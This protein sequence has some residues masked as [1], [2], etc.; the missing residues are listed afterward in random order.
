[1]VCGGQGLADL[2][3]RKCRDTL[4]NK[5]VFNTTGCT[6]GSVCKPDGKSS[7]RRMC[8]VLLCSHPGLSALPPRRQHR[9]RKSM[10]LRF[11]SL[12]AGHIASKRHRKKVLIAFI[13]ATCFPFVGQKLPS[14]RQIPT[15]NFPE[16]FWLAPSAGSC[17][18][19]VLSKTFPGCCL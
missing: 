10:P 14:L 5:Q 2:L 17:R 19:F 11:E 15:K 3:H 9:S 13:A 16:N 8:F 7:F 1:M 18:G 4:F 6:P 12:N